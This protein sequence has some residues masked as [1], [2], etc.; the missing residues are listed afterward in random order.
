MKREPAGTPRRLRIASKNDGKVAEIRKALEGIVSPGTW[1]IVGVGADEPEPSET[2]TTFEDNAIL[3]A[4]AYDRQA[5][6]PPA[7]QSATW[8]LADDSG[9]EVDA[10]HG[11]PGVR[12]ARYAPTDPERIARLLGELGGVGDERR[13]A[14][15]VCVLAL[16]HEGQ[17]VWTGRGE[18][19]GRIAPEPRGTN[20][21]GY[22]PVF[23]LPDIGSTMAELDP[24]TK[25]RFSHRG[26]ALARL[27]KQLHAIQVSAPPRRLL[28]PETINRYK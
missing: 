3:K 11:R 16:A 18:I 27:M 12:S 14:R 13:T 15:F 25:N 7:G 22:D 1:S 2:G 20:G 8:T 9:L 5:A 23:L 21:F 28:A 4:L 26:R 19:E 10:I 6:R 24:D 17:I